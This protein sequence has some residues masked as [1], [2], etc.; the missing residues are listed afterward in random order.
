MPGTPRGPLGV[1]FSTPRSNAILGKAL[2]PSGIAKVTRLA[3]EGD[4]I[5]II[6]ADVRNA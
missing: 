6:L 1:D 3:I 5:D 4:E 2:K